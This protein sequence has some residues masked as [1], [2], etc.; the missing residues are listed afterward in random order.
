MGPPGSATLFAVCLMNQN[1]LKYSLKG[2][3]ERMALTVP[4]ARQGSQVIHFYSSNY[5][6]I[7]HANKI[8]PPGLQGV[9]GVQGA[10]GVQGSP[11]PRG[12]PGAVGIQGPTGNP[13]SPGKDGLPGQNGR[14]GMDGK[15]GKV[16]ND[17]PPGLPGDRVTETAIKLTKR[18]LFSN[19]V[20]RSRRPERQGWKRW[21]QR[22]AGISRC[23]R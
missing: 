6:L 14:D 11:G 21:S 20:I 15:N 18:L 1:H 19:L 7:Y 17:G 8:G 23:P 2:H 16:G 12:F 9:Q 13:G 10:Q 3:R 22:W 4:S 5:E